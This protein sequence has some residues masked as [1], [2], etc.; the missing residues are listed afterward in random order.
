M[1][2]P[3]VIH[4][5]EAALKQHLQDVLSHRTQ[6]LYRML[7]VHF[8]WYPS[9]SA[10]SLV[11]L[12]HGVACLM[13]CD[14]LGGKQERALPAAAAV[15]FAAQHIQLHSGIYAKGTT[16]ASSAILTC[17]QAQAINAGDSLHALARLSIASLEERGVP[18]DA[19]LTCFTRLDHALVD[20]AEEQFDASTRQD[21]RGSPMGGALFGCALE[22]GAVIAGVPD[23][24]AANL[25][26]AGRT[27]G[28]AL[29]GS[30]PRKAH[31][32]GQEALAS[33][34]N[35]G[36]PTTPM[37]NLKEVFQF[38]LAQEAIPVP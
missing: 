10:P 38:L 29:A 2:P 8:G 23:R 21:K 9:K 31:S 28:E 17:G 15:E 3:H 33:L 30:T 26:E 35:T 12:R 32:H 18:A 22:L 6:P 13:T 37:A 19:V 25:R 5:Y 24:Q 7:D 36:L 20:A 34:A 1:R 27:L 14:A 4:L 11:S 16:S